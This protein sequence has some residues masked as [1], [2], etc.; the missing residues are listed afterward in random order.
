[1]RRWKKGGFDALANWVELS[2]FGMLIAGFVLGKAVV[3][4]TFAHVL[5]A[6]AGLIAG[7][8][9]YVKRQNDPVPFQAISLA[10]II[11]YLIGHRTGNGFVII[12]VFAAAAAAS[13]Y[14]H[15][16]LDS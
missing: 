6:T 16:N 12:A 15:K 1:M 5:V 11:G 13:Y 3:D 14:L 7:R 4:I 8:L 10:F 9:V 2:F